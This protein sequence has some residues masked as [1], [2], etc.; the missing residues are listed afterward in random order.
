MNSCLHFEML[1]KREVSLHPLTEA[2]NG[3]KGYDQDYISVCSKCPS[4]WLSKIA[5]KLKTD[6]KTAHSSEL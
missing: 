5:E 3:G 1:K 4:E 6:D 2:G